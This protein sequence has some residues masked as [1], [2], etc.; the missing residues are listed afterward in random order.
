M[1]V[2]YRI[3]VWIPLGKCSRWYKRD[4][5]LSWMIGKQVFEKRDGWTT[6]FSYPMG[7]GVTFPGVEQPVK[8]AWSYSSTLPYSSWCSAYLSTEATLWLSYPCPFLSCL[9]RWVLLRRLPKQSMIC[10]TLNVLE[11][12]NFFS[13]HLERVEFHRSF[14]LSTVQEQNC[15]LCLVVDLTKPVGGDTRVS[16]VMQRQIKY[17]NIL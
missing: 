8:Y 15:R 6:S 12:R 11:T 2:L 3:L 13:M 10:M 14:V 17:E 16:L 1:C 9:F 7:K 5:R 4:G